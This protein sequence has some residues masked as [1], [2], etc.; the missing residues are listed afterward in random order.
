MTLLPIEDGRWS[1][2]VKF[3][4]YSL[5]ATIG[6]REGI[7][8]RWE[9][10]AGNVGWGDAAPLPGWSTDSLEDV[11]R[12]ITQPARSESVPP[13]LVCAFEA[14][15]AGLMGFHYWKIRHTHLSL[16]ALLEGSEDDVFLGA[17]KAFERGCRCFKIKVARISPTRLPVLLKKIRTSTGGFCK[18]RIDPNRAWNL[19]CTRSVASEVRD[20]QVEYFEEPVGSKS[21]MAELIQDCPVGIA[22]DETLRE[23]TPENLVEYRGAAALVLKPTLMGGF[24]KCL[25]FAEAGEALG[26]NSVVSGSYESGV[27]IY[28]LARFALSL[29][30]ISAAGLDTYSRLNEDVFIERLEFPDF[31]FTRTTQM[32]DVD[33]SK[34]HSF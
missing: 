12:F 30:R 25:E 24:Q 28:A 29:P 33:F 19:D 14:A 8:V 7:L 13:S 31:S 22:L 18:F 3:F 5:S 11:F 27:G 21:Q 20:F 9:N 15:Q 1:K 34:L 4:R 17:L 16:N 26:M 10:S 32:P 6:R 2:D 23:I